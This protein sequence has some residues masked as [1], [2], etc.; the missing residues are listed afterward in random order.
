MF[1]NRKTTDNFFDEI[2]QKITGEIQQLSDD[3]ILNADYDELYNYYY[4][5]NVIEK[6]TL[7]LEHIDI[8]F[9]ETK[10]QRPSYGYRTNHEYVDVDGYKISY[11]IPF[12]GD[13]RLFQYVPSTFYSSGL[14]EYFTIDGRNGEY[15]KILYSISYAKHEIPENANEDFAKTQFNSKYDLHINNI[16]NLNNDANRFIASLE[17]IIKNALNARKQ[18]V[19]DFINLSKKLD[20]PLKKN[21]NAPNVKPILLKKVIKTLPQMPKKK[22]PETYSAISD[23]DYTNIR[24]IISLAG[25]SFEKAARSFSSFSEETLS[26]IIIASL[27]T[28]Y[29]GTATRE[30][31]SKNGKTDIHLPFDNKSAYIAECKIW[32]GE[33]SFK[34]AIE[35]L[36]SYTT[37][38][39][40]K[41]SLIIFNKENKD[42]RKV[43]KTI[44]T[45]LEKDELCK[46]KIQPKENEWLC[47]FIKDKENQSLITVQIIVFD[48]CV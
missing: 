13:K 30:T 6:I 32:H 8:S 4:Q 34:K 37:W 44:Q 2:K 5:K 3:E 9:T 24:Q 22:Q 1:P 12:E 15:S 27:N 14:P 47:D 36:F 29:L 11:E 28:H 16:N 40:V 38:R 7:F 42:F 23:N 31:F 20:I 26:D 39:N 46:N 48:L 43:L 21:P 35:Q 25:F 19:N 33:E 45:I 10:V 17:H 41:T 18:K